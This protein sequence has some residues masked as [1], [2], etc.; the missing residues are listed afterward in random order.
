LEVR[1]K[2]PA[3]FQ[4]EIQQA[5]FKQQPLTATANYAG[6]EIK[7]S[8]NRLSGIADAR[9]ID[10]LFNITSGNKWVRPG[11]SIS[12]SLKRPDKENVI[13]LPYS[14]VYDNSRIYRII[15]HRLQGIN[16]QISGNYLDD[17]SEKLLVYSPKISSG[18]II[19]VTHLPNAINGLKVEF[20]QP[21][22]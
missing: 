20:S 10:A 6:A 3:S 16:I 11:S 22:S 12:L 19:L 1:A 17:N 5:I 15:N 4:H 18:D 7:L 9:G 13:A 21:E 2:I 8:L 14:A